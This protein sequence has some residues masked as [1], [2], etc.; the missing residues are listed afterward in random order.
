M[1]NKKYKKYKLKTKIIYS[2]KQFF[3]SYDTLK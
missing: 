2:Y 3:E 1:L